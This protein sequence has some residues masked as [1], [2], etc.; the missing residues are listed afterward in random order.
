MV[1]TYANFV[2]GNKGVKITGNECS[3]QFLFFG[4][5]YVMD[6]SCATSQGLFGG[7]WPMRAWQA[8]VS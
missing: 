7:W 1:S 3:K 8:A 2:G 4:S 6:Q 5:N